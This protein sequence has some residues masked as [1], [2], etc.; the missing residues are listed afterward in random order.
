[1]RAFFL[2]KEGTSF[3]MTKHREIIFQC[4]QIVNFVV[5]KFVIRGKVDRVDRN[6]YIIKDIFL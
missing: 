3:S 6:F 4:S 1:M 2:G 5:V